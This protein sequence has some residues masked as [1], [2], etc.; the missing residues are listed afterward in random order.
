M[1]GPRGWTQVPELHEGTKIVFVAEN[2]RKALLIRY[3]SPS[4]ILKAMRRDRL[5]ILLKELFTS[6]GTNS[7]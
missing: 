4:E 3:T 2:R 7:E 6:R 1:S 5:V